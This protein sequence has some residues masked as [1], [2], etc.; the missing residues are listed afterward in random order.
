MPEY[1]VTKHSLNIPRL[2]SKGEISKTSNVLAIGGRTIVVSEA[3]AKPFLATGQ[4]ETVREGEKPE[5]TKPAETLD[6]GG[7][8][9]QYPERPTKAAGLDKWQEAAAKRNLDTSG[10][11]ADLQRRVEEFDAARDA[12]DGKGSSEN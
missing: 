5:E 10:T 4:L 11:K 6:Q 12:G 7:D 1:K 3:E 2:D 8:G 9:G